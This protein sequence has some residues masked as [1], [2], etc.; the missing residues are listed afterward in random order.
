MLRAWVSSLAPSSLLML[1]HVHGAWSSDNVFQ[2]CHSYIPSEKANFFV[3]V[4][5]DV[6]PH[7]E[8]IH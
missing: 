4:N 6:L 8:G 1:G 3:V 2:S 5:F 7:C